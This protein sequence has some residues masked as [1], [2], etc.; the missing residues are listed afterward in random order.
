MQVQEESPVAVLNSLK[1]ARELVD[2][3]DILFIADTAGIPDEML[4]EAIDDIEAIQEM[5]SEIYEPI[6]FQLANNELAEIEAEEQAV[7]N[8]HA[9]EGASVE[10][11]SEPEPADAV[12]P[13]DDKARARGLLFAGYTSMCRRIRNRGRESQYDEQYRQQLFAEYDSLVEKMAETDRADLR[14]REKQYHARACKLHEQV[15]A[16]LKFWGLPETPGPAAHRCPPA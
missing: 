13:P 3:C 11:E 8:G 1:K 15:L 5:C 7:R 4:R 16:M 10:P 6:S 14:E 9:A 12:S 2:A